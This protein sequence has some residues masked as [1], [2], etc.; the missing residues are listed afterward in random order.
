MNHLRISLKCWFWFIDPVGAWYSTF[1]TTPK[2]ILH[3][4][5]PNCTLGNKDPH[6]FCLIGVG[7]HS[8]LGVDEGCPLSH[9]LATSLYQKQV[10][11]QAPVTCEH[12][13]ATE[14]KTI[15]KPV[16]EATW[17]HSSAFLSAWL[18]SLTIHTSHS[19][20]K[21]W[22]SKCGPRSSISPGNLV[23]TQILRPSPELQN[24]KIWEWGQG[25]CI[26]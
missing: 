25:I 22:F 2:E 1:L 3:C 7:S 19:P 26:F 17:S 21:Q 9:I 6:S 10:S 16:P 15:V 8:W 24:Q 18:K 12:L 13:L 23:E 20:L 5:F 11:E 4:W 14:H